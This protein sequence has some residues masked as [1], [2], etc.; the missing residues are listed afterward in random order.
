MARKA[1]ME[2]G[3]NV[4]ARLPLALHEQIDQRTPYLPGGTIAGFTRYAVHR[5]M[6][7]ILDAEGREA[8]KGGDVVDV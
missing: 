2:P 3:V 8:D 7:R 6:E 4:T 1:N 5:E